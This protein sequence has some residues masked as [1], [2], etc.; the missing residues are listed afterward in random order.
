MMLFSHLCDS[1]TLF[2]TN[3]LDGFKT[4]DLEGVSV[5]AIVQVKQQPTCVCKR[6]LTVFVYQLAADVVSGD[7]LHDHR[8]LVGNGKGLTCAYV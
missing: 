1:G 8:K 6:V 4:Y 3:T 2:N 5:A 7:A